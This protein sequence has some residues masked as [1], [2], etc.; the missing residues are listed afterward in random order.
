MGYFERLLE[1]ERNAEIDVPNGNS[2]TDNW[3]YENLP[4]DSRQHYTFF[5]HV[6]H[7][8]RELAKRAN[9][10]G[11][12]NLPLL[13]ADLD[14]FYSEV[15]IGRGSEFKHGL[16][17][18]FLQMSEGKL[19]DE[20]TEFERPYGIQ[21]CLP[22]RARDYADK[23][24][25]IYE[26][27]K[28][29]ALDDKRHD[30]LDV[31]A[32][33]D[34]LGFFYH[35]VSIGR[36]SEFG[37]SKVGEYIH[38]REM[39]D[40][41]LFG[42]IDDSPV[43]GGTRGLSGFTP[44]LSDGETIASRVLVTGM[45]EGIDVA[46]LEI[47][48]EERHDL[49]YKCREWA[50][51]IKDSAMIAQQ[52]GNLD[53]NGL[54]CAMGFLFHDAAFPRT[55]EF[56]DSPVGEFIRNSKEGKVTAE[57]N[58]DSYLDMCLSEVNYNLDSATRE[59]YIEVLNKLKAAAERLN[60]TGELVI[61]DL[62]EAI[63]FV[64]GEAKEG[65]TSEFDNGV[66]AEFISKAKEAGKVKD[67][68]IPFADPG[69]FLTQ[70]ELERQAEELFGSLEPRVPEPEFV[71]QDEVDANLVDIVPSDS[72]VGPR[73]Y[74]EY[75][76]MLRTAAEMASAGGT[77]DVDALFDAL[78]FLYHEAN[79]G[80]ASEFGDSPFGEFIRY[81]KEGKMPPEQADTLSY[82]IQ[83]IESVTGEKHGRFTW[84]YIDALEK[85][86]KSARTLDELGRLDM[87]ELFEAVSFVYG[88][89]ARG[90][91][92][93]FDNGIVPEFCQKAR[94]EAELMGKGTI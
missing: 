16:I 26:Q 6:L 72:N 29:T 17:G 50:D 54:M 75:N 46:L 9:A 30:A 55:S 88:E 65:R 40:Q 84:D 63:S 52:N 8:M 43:L 60:G 47:I 37:D 57:G 78:G 51:M 18:D 74:K 91:S 25:D 23:Y 5:K 14:F 15:R 85:L 31:D 67:E 2:L 70:E 34:A 80:R 19:E 24:Y 48:P 10:N 68:E 21:E 89:A 83:M 27:I 4:E 66:V 93:E 39:V 42:E 32:L 49:Y 56:A 64:Y 87:R 33:F 61:H 12:L 59:K 69:Y 53:L 28:K 79:I 35:E 11:T 94:N 22:L 1:I 3:M 13:F 90:R 71:P 45:Y 41:A 20:P 86:K 58:I 44:S 92:S 62:I 82:Q 36:A 77:L 73:T 76:D 38:H 7:D 81:S